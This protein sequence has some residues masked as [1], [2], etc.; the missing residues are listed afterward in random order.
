MEVTLLNNEGNMSISVI[1]FKYPS[2]KNL[3]LGW[4]KN[5]MWLMGVW[6]K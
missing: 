4:S 2:R 1:I 3:M 6:E 5:Y